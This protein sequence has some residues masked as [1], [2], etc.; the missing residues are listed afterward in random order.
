LKSADWVRQ[1]RSRIN[2]VVGFL[3]G[4]AAIA[5][6]VVLT[7]ISN[8]PCVTTNV[9]FPIA[10]Y[11]NQY[12]CIGPTTIQGTYTIPNAVA[13]DFLIWGIIATLLLTAVRAAAG[14]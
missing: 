7:P 9:G 13:L 12:T 5:L 3:I 14:R 10:F 11:T 2:L 1:L 4:A 8:V 6:M